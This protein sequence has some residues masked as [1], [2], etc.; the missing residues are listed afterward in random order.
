[1]LHADG[2]SLSQVWS[3]G[4]S[5]QPKPTPEQAAEMLAAA[6]PAEF[7]LEQIAAIRSI[8][9]VEA[10]ALMDAWL[11]EFLRLSAAQRAE[12]LAAIGAK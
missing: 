9:V 7:T 6:M 11:Q 5:K 10:R 4:M 3:S 8:A 2:G 1:M 12:L